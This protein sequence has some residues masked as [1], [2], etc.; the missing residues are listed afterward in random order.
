MTIMSTPKFD[1]Y[2][3]AIVESISDGAFTVDP[4]WQITYFNSAAERIT[5]VPRENAIGMHC[6]E[7]FLANICEGRCAL[8][9]TIETGKPV[10]SKQ[11]YIVRADGRRIPISIS[12]AILKDKNGNIIGGVETFRDMSVIEELRKKIYK[13]YTIADI[14]SK[15]KRMQEIFQILPQIAESDST[16]LI[17]GASGTGKELIA[18]AIHNLSNRKGKKFVAINC[19]ALP[20][21]LLESELF[22]YK[23]GAF[24]GAAK[25]KPGRFDQA[26]S[27]TIFLDEIGDIS[28]AMQVKLLR[29]LQ[30]RVFEPLGAVE[31]VKVNTRVIASSNRDISQ[32]TRENL[33]RKDLYYRINVIDIKLPDLKERKDDIPLLVGHFVEKFNCLKNKSIKAVS[34]DVMSILLSHDFPG[35]VRELENI[36]EHAFV[37]CLG[38]IIE[39]K[40]LPENLSK[41]KIAIQAVPESLKDAEKQFIVQVLERHNWNRNASAKALNIHKST[42]FR[43]LKALGI[44]LSN[45]GDQGTT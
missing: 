33:F 13:K 3:T 4:N 38:Q 45:K 24:T 2:T 41:Q 44:Q 40:H 12:T 1:D 36:I 16:V 42:L 21:T 6:W 23:A 15:N 32:L 10:V 25:D 7:V 20:D 5:G 30:E 11:I 14:I 28:P 26:Q 34:P 37:L 29:V 31:S 17:E 39:V 9:K 22:G 35:N 19:G 8:K 27:G 43:K 18:R